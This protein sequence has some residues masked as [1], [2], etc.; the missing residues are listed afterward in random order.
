MWGKL[1][2]RQ[3]LNPTRHERW[4]TPD[5]DF[6]DLHRLAGSDSEVPRL[7]IL[8]GLEGT[9]R[10]HYAQGLLGEAR[11]RGWA[12]DMLIFRSCGE[13]L[14]RTRRFYHSGETTDVAFVID[15]ILSTWGKKA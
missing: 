9:I 2:R 3:A 13:E 5:G 15:R 12:A 7:L 1:F 14:N 10:S 11:N 8:H 6:I 4:D